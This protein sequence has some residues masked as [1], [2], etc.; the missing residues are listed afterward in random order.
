MQMKAT[1]A[2]V[3]CCAALMTATQASALCIKAPEANL[4]KG[5]GTNHEKSWEV[6]KYMPLRK[7]DEKGDWYHVQDVDGDRHWVY[8]KLVT[9]SMRCGIVQVPEA[10]VRTG[11]GTNHGTSPLSPVEKYYSFRVV[12]TRGD[13][14]KVEDA[15]SNEGWV[16][17][18]LLWIQ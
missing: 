6:F 16:Y 4:R 18:P 2:A 10:N 9:D 1:A 14:V 17:K 12:E 11:P 3:L 13:W 7:I 5:P 15:V 8:R